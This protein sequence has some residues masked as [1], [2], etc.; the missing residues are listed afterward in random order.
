M[1]C[2]AE[3]TNKVSGFARI[4]LTVVEQN[5]NHLKGSKISVPVSELITYKQNTEGT[6]LRLVGRKSIQVMESTA[7]IDRLVRAAWEN[8]RP[9]RVAPAFA[10]MKHAA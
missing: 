2:M 6:Q 10:S 3:S 9:L 1:N 4:D 7:Q 5:L 8:S